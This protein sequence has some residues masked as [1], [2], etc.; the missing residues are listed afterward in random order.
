M[1]K[2]VEFSTLFMKMIKPSVLSHVLISILFIYLSWE[3]IATFLCITRSNFCFV[4]HLFFH[5]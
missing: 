3:V 1:P 4:Y 5:L 2:A